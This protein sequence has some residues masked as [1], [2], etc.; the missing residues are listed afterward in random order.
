MTRERHTNNEVL[1]ARRAGKQRDT[2]C[3]VIH[4]WLARRARR[5]CMGTRMLV[6]AMAT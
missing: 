4:M 2:S 3:H 5:R 6:V 1:E